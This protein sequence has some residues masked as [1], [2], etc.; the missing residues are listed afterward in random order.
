M[1]KK[2]FE[3]LPSEALVAALAKLSIEFFA[4]N[5]LNGFTAKSYGVYQSHRGIGYLIESG[6][7]KLT[8][9]ALAPK[10]VTKKPNAKKKT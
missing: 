7:I 2:P 6:L 10:K 1:K 5:V 8:P 3:V 4:S 9:K